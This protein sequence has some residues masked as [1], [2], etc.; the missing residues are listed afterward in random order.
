MSCASKSVVID[1]KEYTLVAA[2]SKISKDYVI[3]RTDRA[4]V[5]IGRLVSQDGQIVRLADARRIWRWRGA[6]TL[7]ELSKVGGDTG[8]TR[9]SEPITEVTLLDAIELVPCTES[10]AKNL[11]VSRWPA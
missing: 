9:I 11:T 10:A 1:G 3:V 4:G 5:H 8:F 7:N 2:D 6:N